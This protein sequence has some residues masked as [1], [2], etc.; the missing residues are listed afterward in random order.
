[1]QRGLGTRAHRS[2]QTDEV[3]LVVRASL[4]GGTVLVHVSTIGQPFAHDGAHVLGRECPRHRG[5]LIAPALEMRSDESWFH[6]DEAR[7]RE[8]EKNRDFFLFSR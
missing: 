3:E 5:A 8:K 7:H 6:N 4:R 1:M 2:T